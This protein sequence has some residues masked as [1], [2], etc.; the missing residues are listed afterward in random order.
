M[1]IDQGLELLDEDECWALVEGTSVGRVGVTV[2]A[3]P[4]IFPVNYTVLD[5]AVVFRTADGS[6]LHAASE[7]T[8]VVFEVDHVD[9]SDRS[10]WS[11]MVLGRAEVVSDL[12]FA[13]RVLDDGLEPWADGVRAR[14]VR[15]TPE[16]VT[17]RRIVHG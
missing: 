9:A 11:V 16:L 10:G 5:G 4:A 3:L 13:L 7:G 17:G 15:I 2:A 1:L 6:K 8:V 14:I 12:G